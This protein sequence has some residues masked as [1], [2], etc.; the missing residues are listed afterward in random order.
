VIR[1]LAVLLAMAGPAIAQE[2]TAAHM[3]GCLVWNREGQ[4]SARNECSR[5]LTLM[6]M[7]FD[8]RESVTADMPPGARFTSANSVWG[9]TGGFIFTACPPGS[10]PSLRFALENKEPIGASLYNCVVGRPTS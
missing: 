9:S 5:P 3:E 4:V 7:D 10:R 2:I 6:F 1:W 8:G